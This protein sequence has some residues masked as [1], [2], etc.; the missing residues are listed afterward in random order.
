MM[1][2]REKV[3]KQLAHVP[4]GRVLT[5]G[6]LARLIGSPNSARAVGNALNKNLNLVRVP[7]HRVVC[8]DGKVGGYAG[9]VLKKVELLRDEGVEVIEGRVNLEKWGV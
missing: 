4:R 8:S 3:L 1:L 9:G 5:Y 6:G 2:F 7:C